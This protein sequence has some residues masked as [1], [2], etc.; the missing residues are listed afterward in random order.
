MTQHV[1]IAHEFTTDVDT[2]LAKIFFDHEFNRQLYLVQ[3]GFPEWLILNETDNGSE[4]VRQVKVS[5]KQ[6]APGPV[7]KLLGDR[8]SYIEDGKFDKATKQY[9]FK[10]TPSSMAERI[11]T[12]GVMR[13]ET[14]QPK[15]IRRV[16]EL[17]IEVKIFGVGGMIESYTAK[18]TKESYDKTATFTQKWLTERE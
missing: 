4:I 8:F 6:D 10:I 15:R 5:P 17:D 1:V 7:Q 14:I 9:R 16:I 2:F 3:L 12:S 13:I 11:N 18:A